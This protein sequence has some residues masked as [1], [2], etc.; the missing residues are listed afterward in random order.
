MYNLFVESDHYCLYQ[1]RKYEINKLI[2]FIYENQNNANV[3]KFKQIKVN[4]HRDILEKACWVLSKNTPAFSAISNNLSTSKIQTITP[5]EIIAA[6]VVY[7][8]EYQKILS[9]DVMFPIVM[10]KGA[11]NNIIFDGHHRLVKAVM[12]DIP[13]IGAY[14]IEDMRALNKYF[15]HTEQVDKK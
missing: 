8:T 7:N 4:D 1:K 11:Y 2:L 12:F 15:G 6:P 5:Q 9:A 14:I 10:I 13:L 3:V